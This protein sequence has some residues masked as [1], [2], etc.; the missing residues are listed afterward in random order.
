MT[1]FPP[2]SREFYGKCRCVQGAAPLHLVTYHGTQG[3]GARAAALTLTTRT[4]GSAHEVHD[5]REGFK[6][7]PDDQI[8]CGVG[9]A[10]TGNYH[11]EDATF[12]S[13]T[14]KIWFLH[15]RTLKWSAYRIAKKLN[16]HKKSCHFVNQEEAD[17][18]RRV[19]DLNGWTYHSI[20]SLTDWCPS[21]H[22]DPGR[23]FP[24]RWFKRYVEF[25]YSNPDVDYPVTLNRKGT[26]K[27]RKR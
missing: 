27:R 13:W 7:A 20:L 18:A 16:Q 14:R 12:A 26:E 19:E 1:P 15:K 11:V 17:A 8:L 4:D 23:F 5:A 9:G 24:H 3:S 10:N 6:L 2:L 21:T 22:T 25:Y